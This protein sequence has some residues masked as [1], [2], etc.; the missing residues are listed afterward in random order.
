MSRLAEA[1]FYCQAEV[2]LLPELYPDLCPTVP[3]FHGNWSNLVSKKSID[4][5][6]NISR[7]SC[8]WKP[9]NP[10]SVKTQIGK[11]PTISW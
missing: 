1:K 9:K 6:M 3:F 4:H 2:I 5:R 7:F 8:L 10:K 11:K